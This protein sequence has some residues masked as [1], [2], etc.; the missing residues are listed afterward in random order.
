MGNT[1]WREVQGRPGSETHAD[2][3]KLLRLEKSSMS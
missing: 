2:M 1:I 3:S